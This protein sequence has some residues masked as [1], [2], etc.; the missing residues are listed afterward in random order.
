MFSELVR[1]PLILLAFELERPPWMDGNSLLLDFLGT[2][3][4][5]ENIM[6]V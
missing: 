2:L 1:R 4:L 5:G 6:T 3:T